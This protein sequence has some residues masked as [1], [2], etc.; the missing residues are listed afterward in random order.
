M[1]IH[2]WKCM[3]M[4]PMAID[5]HT[6][7]FSFTCAKLRE[8]P[9]DQGFRFFASLPSYFGVSD[10]LVYP[11]GKISTRSIDPY[12]KFLISC[13]VALCSDVFVIK[14]MEIHRTCRRGASI[15]PPYQKLK[16][17]KRFGNDCLAG[18]ACRVRVMYTAIPLQ[19]LTKNLIIIKIIF[20]ACN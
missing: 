17:A 11:M 6:C 10:F 18:R 14:S 1:E 7:R 20:I 12:E 5:G 16:N 2:V 15:W 9:E 8:N 4:P 3:G 13:L 19:S